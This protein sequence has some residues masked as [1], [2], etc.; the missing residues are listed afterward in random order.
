[1]Y[2]VRLKFFT[3]TYQKWDMGGICSRGFYNDA[4]KLRQEKGWRE[5]DVWNIRHGKM[6]LKYSSKKTIL[7]RNTLAIFSH[8]FP[9][10]MKAIVEGVNFR[11]RSVRPTQ[12]NQAGGFVDR[13]APIHISNLMVIHNEQATRIGYK[14]LE[15]GSKIR[16]SVKNGEEI[17]S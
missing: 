3:P 17:K 4:A 8:I 14:K 11:K 9:K 2:N 16:I 7:L 5:E 12:D 13:E 6:S 1:M 10:K 15:D